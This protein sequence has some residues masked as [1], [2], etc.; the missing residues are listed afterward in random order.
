MLT[1]IYIEALLVDKELADQVWKAW[2]K[3][4]INDAT[5]HLAWGIIYLPR[6]QTLRAQQF[7]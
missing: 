1:C 6:Y 4:E 2:D 7:L 3:G 5:A